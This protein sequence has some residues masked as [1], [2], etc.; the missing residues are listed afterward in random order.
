MRLTDIHH[1]EPNDLAEKSVQVVQTG[2]SAGS[3]G[4]GVRTEYDQSRPVFRKISAPKLVAARYG[5]IKLHDVA[6][7]EIVLRE[8]HVTR[9]VAKLQTF[10]SVRKRIRHQKYI[11][12]EDERPGWPNFYDYELRP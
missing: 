7:S 12:I 11:R 6:G 10:K 1:D 3:H 5:Q 8:Q 2:N 4:A 9:N